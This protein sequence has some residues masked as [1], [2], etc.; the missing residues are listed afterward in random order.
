MKMLGAILIPAVLVTLALQLHLGRAAAEE[1]EPQII[2]MEEI[3]PE[4][5]RQTGPTAAVE[6]R[7]TAVRILSP[8]GVSPAEAMTRIQPSEIKGTFAKLG[9]FEPIRSLSRTPVMIAGLGV[10]LAVAGLAVFLWI[11]KRRG[12]VVI[13]AGGALITAGVMFE[14][15]PWVALMLPVLA[16]A[17]ALW[18]VLATRRGRQIREEL[19]LTEKALRETVAGVE[20]YK[21]RA[22]GQKQAVNA[23]LSAEQDRETKHRIRAIKGRA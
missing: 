23:D 7:T 16:L 18:F 6:E 3:T 4:E 5:F 21:A 14:Q 13:A 8:F 2:E 20:R 11:D 17:G 12:A 19:G 9:G 10:I 1:S 15:Y 22:P